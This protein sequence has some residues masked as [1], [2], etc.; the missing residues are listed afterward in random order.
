MNNEQRHK[1]REKKSVQI[2][3]L[4]ISCHI[5]EP[6]AIVVVLVSVFIPETVWRMMQ[7]KTHKN[8]LLL[9]H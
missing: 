2:V 7:L 4:F 3:L 5:I 1:S 8:E 6:E 9:H